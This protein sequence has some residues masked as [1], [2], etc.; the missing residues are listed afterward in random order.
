MS[1]ALGIAHCALCIVHCALSIVCVFFRMPPLTCPQI[2]NAWTTQH[3][4][5]CQMHVSVMANNIV[6]HVI[7]LKQIHQIGENSS[8]YLKYK[9]NAHLYFSPTLRCILYGSLPCEQYF[10]KSSTTP[11]QVS[12]SIVLEYL[13]FRYHA[14]CPMCHTSWCLGP[15]LKSK[16]PALSAKLSKQGIVDKDFVNMPCKKYCVSN[17]QHQFAFVMCKNNL[18]FTL[19]L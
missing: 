19:M 8:P 7:V 3:L 18:D 14:C 2:S 1:L 13:G 17:W 16:W 5:A 9:C 4:F 10:A 12:S 15:T 11:M 6:H